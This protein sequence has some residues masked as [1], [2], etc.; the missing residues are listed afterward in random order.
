VI[1]GAAIC[2][3]DSATRRL[4]GSVQRLTIGRMNPPA[5]ARPQRALVGIVLLTC[6]VPSFAHHSAAMFDPKQSV[7][8]IGTINAFQWTSPHCWI[9]LS[10]DGPQGAV[11]WS[12]QMGSTL[13]LY[14]SGW[15]PSTLES[16]EKI[17]IVAH[18]MRNGSHGGLFVSAANTDGTPLKT[19]SAGSSTP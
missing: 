17:T 8:L 4:R 3:H 2:D 1:V 6:T 9:Q 18:P 11:E 15:R 19:K 13:E 12:I 7:T 16:G 5:F 10:V 14:R